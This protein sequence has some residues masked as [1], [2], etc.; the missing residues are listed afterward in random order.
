LGRGC[1]K[2]SN[3]T[4]RD[5]GFAVFEDEALRACQKK[6]VRKVCKVTYCNDINRTH[7]RSQ[8]TTSDNDSPKWKTDDVLLDLWFIEITKNI[9][10]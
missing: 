10:A 4:G 2:G 3:L 8:N 9:E 6:L 1:A 7:D 5:T